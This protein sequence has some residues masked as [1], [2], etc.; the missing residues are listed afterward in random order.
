MR[1]HRPCNSGISFGPASIHSD[2]KTFSSG[3]YTLLV[4]LS[5]LLLFCSSAPSAQ[6]QG[7]LTTSPDIMSFGHVSVGSS[8]SGALT[9]KN[10]GNQTLTV[11]GQVLTGSGFSASGLKFPKTLTVGESVSFTVVFAPTQGGSASGTLQLLSNTP[12]PAI[13]YL[14]ATGVGSSS[15]SGSGGSAAP[16]YL[17][18]NSLTA[19]F[20]TVAVGTENTETVQLTNTGGESLSISSIAAKGTGFSVSGFKT[21]ITLAAGA[22]TQFTVAFLPESATSFSG[23]VLVTSTASDSQITIVLTGTGGSSSRIMNVNPSSVTFGSVNVNGSATRQVTLTNG[24]NSSLT[25]STA[26]ISGTGLSATGVGNNTTLAA[27]QSAV[28]VADFS[29][30]AA[31]SIAGTITVKSNASDATVTVPVTGT[32]SATSALTVALEWA[33][34]TSSGVVG[35]NV[36][37]STVSGGPYGK[38]TASPVPSTAYSDSSVAAGA[39]YYYVVTAVNSAGTESSYS[40]Q[41][42]VSVP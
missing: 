27:G 12:S 40:N 13:V 9:L 30:K 39:E 25:I 33:A 19:S 24:G 5:I 37:R 4:V 41:V 36:Y 10:T 11:S 35:Y 18:A 14:Y 29:P 6:A 3:G 22:S 15:G 34:S 2:R 28:L 7:R 42:A 1:A 16:A 26:T 32:G 38:E 31:G 20:G 17:T 23:S 8:H 21:P